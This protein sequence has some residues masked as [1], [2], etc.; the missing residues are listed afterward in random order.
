M[1]PYAPPWLAQA[2]GVRGVPRKSMAPGGGENWL[3]TTGSRLERSDVSFSRAGGPPERTVGSQAGWGRS[4][5]KE[6]AWCGLVKLVPGGSAVSR[7]TGFPAPTQPGWRALRT[8]SG[9]AFIHRA[10][11]SW[12]RA[13]GPAAVCREELCNKAVNE[14]S[15]LSWA[16]LFSRALLI[17]LFVSELSSSLELFVQINPSP[18]TFHVSFCPFN[19]SCQVFIPDAGV[20]QTTAR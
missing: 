11:A 8:V 10:R 20:S 18:L 9:P 19:I 14:V 3:T 13:Q 5:Q 7:E 2:P 16:P 6:F 12:N 4:L 17:L 15:Q 1:W